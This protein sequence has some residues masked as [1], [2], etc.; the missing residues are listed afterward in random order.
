MRRKEERLQRYGRNR[1]VGVEEICQ[2]QDLACN[3]CLTSLYRPGVHK[4]KREN[5]LWLLGLRPG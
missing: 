4:L 5:L 3:H 1:G 2:A